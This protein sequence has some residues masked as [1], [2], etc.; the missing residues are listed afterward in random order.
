M[1]RC[2]LLW[3]V[4]AAASLNAQ[5]DLALVTKNYRFQDG[6]YLSFHS[7]QT[8]NPDLRW[9]EVEA[10]WYTN[11]QT[12]VTQLEGLRLKN[13]KPGLSPDQIWGFS[14]QGIPYIR[15]SRDWIQ[16]ELATFAPLQLRG[17]ICYFEFD[18]IDTTQV[19]ITAY[20][21]SNGLP[22]R[23]GVVDKQQEVSC[24]KIL[25]FETGEVADFNRENLIAWIAD[26][27][28]LVK[29]VRVLTEEEAKTK[30]FKS[31]LIYVDRN[32]VYISGK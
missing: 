22:F 17:K 7:F 11:P 12:F 1:R 13:G 32:E 19:V 23:R 16:K 29:A 24:P 6:I 4:L 28:E 5:Q 31:L 9:E 26:D 15:L 21:P 30:L 20:N 3:M 14:L 27:P 18:R 25:R 2:F 8:D 10:R